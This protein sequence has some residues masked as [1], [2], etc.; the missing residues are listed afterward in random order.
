[1][2]PHFDGNQRPDLRF[3]KNTCFH[4]KL[5]FYCNLH[6]YGTFKRHKSMKSLRF[7][8]F[9]I[10][11]CAKPFYFTIEKHLLMKKL[12]FLKSGIS[13]WEKSGLYAVD[14]FGVGGNP[15]VTVVV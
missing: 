15:I 11:K 14:A 8:C 10:S 1:M 4:K 13:F 7:Q 9:Y 5:F 3:K 2:I 6:G 12:F